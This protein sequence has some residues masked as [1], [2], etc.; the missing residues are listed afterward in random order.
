MLRRLLIKSL[1][2][3]LVDN[4]LTLQGLYTIQV[5]SYGRLVNA[6]HAL[7]EYQEAINLLSTSFK[8]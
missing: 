5:E 8:E 3:S 2:R 1:L 6:Y 7:G 4:F